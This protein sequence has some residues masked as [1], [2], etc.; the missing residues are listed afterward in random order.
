MVY[1]VVSLNTIKKLPRWSLFSSY[2]GGMLQET[3]SFWHSSSFAGMIFFQSLT[4]FIPEEMFFC[5]IK[6]LLWDLLEFLVLVSV[7][8]LPMLKHSL[9]INA[10]LKKAS[11]TCSVK[12]WLWKT[13]DDEEYW[14]E[15]Q[16]APYLRIQNAEILKWGF[17]LRSCNKYERRSKIS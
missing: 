2:V 5:G 3:S 9:P 4:S 6:D 16:K 13:S 7:S 11:T 1:I 12:L 17:S 10:S 15:S 14:K 8:S